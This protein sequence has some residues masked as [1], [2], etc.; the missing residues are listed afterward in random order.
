MSK[1]ILYTIVLDYKGG[2]YV[3]QAAGS[4]ARSALKLWISRITN[5]ELREWKITRRELSGIPKSDKPVQL[6]GRLNVWCLSGLVRNNLVLINVVATRSDP[7]R[8]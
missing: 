8:E 5:R 3:G 2:T 4:S 6:T 1:E 7:H